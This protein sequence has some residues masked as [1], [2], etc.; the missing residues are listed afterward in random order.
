MAKGRHKRTRKKPLWAKLLIAVIVVALLL[1]LTAV[2]GFY[3]VKHDIE[4]QISTVPTIKDYKRPEPLPEKTEAL[5]IL[6]L[7]SD[8]R[9]G[10]NGAGIGGD[11]PGLSDTAVLMHIAADR[12]FVYGVSIPRDSMVERPECPAKD[13]NGTVPAEFAMFNTAYALGGPACTMKTVETITN[14]PINHFVVV[15][16][17]GFKE[18]VDKIGGVEMCVPNEVNDPIGDIY[19]KAGT[20]NMKGKT[21]LDYVR[22]RHGIGDVD[23]GDIGRMKRQ[24]AFMSAVLGKLLDQD[25][26]GDPI[27]TYDIAKTVAGTLTTDEELGSV[28]TLGKL[29]MSMRG[30]DMNGI[31]FFTVP[32]EL[33]SQ[34]RNR[35]VWTEKADVVWQGMINDVRVTEKLLEN[36]EFDGTKPLITKKNKKKN[37]VGQTVPDAE[38]NNEEKV[39]T[40]DTVNGIC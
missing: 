36:P 31:D 23:T 8:T 19:L 16:F 15:D 20:Y 9:E 4:S 40:I 28:T 5:N 13:G 39:G 17:S 11:T 26:I 30:V 6:V 29:G 10:D 32:F 12:E 35:I 25:I 14:V 34:D 2:G 1:A 7:G 27:Q 24:Q 3:Y 21:A 18:I 33:W 37:G 22:V 38:Q